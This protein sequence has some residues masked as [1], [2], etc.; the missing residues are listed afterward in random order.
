MRLFPSHSS[1]LQES[2]D[3]ALTYAKKH[4]Q[5]VEPG[6]AFFSGGVALH[7]HIPEGATPKDGPSAGVTMVT[8]LL[9]LALQRVV[10]AGLAMTG[11]VTLTGKVLAIGGV[12]EKVIAAKRSRV[13]HVLL[14]DDNRRDWQELD[15]A[16]KQDMEVTFCAQY[17]DVFKAVWGPKRK[18]RAAAKA[19]ATAAATQAPAQEPAVKEGEEDEEEEPET[20]P[21]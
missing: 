1:F 21:E 17:E 16:I 15:A 7:M 12:K 10:P 4:L 9:S 14:P 6:N 13:S 3:I 11:E 20:T 8:S 19:A 5:R 2:T 18:S